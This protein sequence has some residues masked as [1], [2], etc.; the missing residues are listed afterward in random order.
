M[1]VK[2]VAVLGA[3]L[4]GHG[5]AQVAAQVGKYE[6]YLRDV[7][8]RF[9]ENGMDMIRN[10]LQKFLS[11]GQITEAEFNETLARIHPTTDL[12][13]AVSKADLIIEAIPENVDLK[14]AVFRE[15]DALAPPHT[16]IA[17]NTSSISITE[18]ASATNR[19]ERVCGMHFFNPPQLMKL[20]EVI[21]GAKTSDETIQTVL[22]VARR[23]QKET[24][25]VKKDCPGFIVNRI[26]I[27][28]LNEAVALYWEGVADRDNI[29]KAIKLGLNWPMGPL[30][31][32]DFI[33]ADT[34]LAIAEVLQ[35]EL[36][37]KFQP[38]PG[39]KMMVKANL[40]GRKTGKG[41]YDWTQK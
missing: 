38:H 4:M 33:G 18:L 27:P 22:E 29:D 28:A 31:L 34:T 12:K 9:L 2:T 25:L 41:F 32:L 37:Q 8:Q 21:K 1:E 36:N 13:E 16:V 24:V 40:L 30:M 7:A 15:V 10:S 14:K 6:V 19:P 23:M 3:G 5:I 39:L 11:K 20:V 17:S 26:L 35:R